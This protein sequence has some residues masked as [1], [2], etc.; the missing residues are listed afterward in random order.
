MSGLFTEREKQMNNHQLSEEIEEFLENPTRS[1]RS[2][3]L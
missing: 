2:F 3:F 1:I